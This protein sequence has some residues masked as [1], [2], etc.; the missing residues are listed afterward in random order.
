MRKRN[1]CSFTEIQRLPIGI[2]QIKK[3]KI[4]SVVWPGEVSKKVTSKKRKTNNLVRVIFAYLLRNAHRRNH[5]NFQHMGGHHQLN[6]LL[7]TT[8]RQD[9]P[10]KLFH[11]HHH[12]HH[13][14]KMEAGL[15]GLC[16]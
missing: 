2:L 1:F 15:K 10:N 9:K 7:I 4:N 16:I 8:T 5:A 11:Y 3:C 13:I 6:Y 14:E 12:H